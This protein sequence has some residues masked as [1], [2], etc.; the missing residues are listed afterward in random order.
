MQILLDHPN[1][2][3]AQQNMRIAQS[4]VDRQKIHLSKH[5]EWRI[6]KNNNVQ[7]I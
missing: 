7:T 4:L 3:L 5:K 1:N 2:S 6:H